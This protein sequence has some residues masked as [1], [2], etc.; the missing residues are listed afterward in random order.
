MLK[1]WNKNPDERDTFEALYN[2]FSNYFINIEP[3]Y[4][5]Y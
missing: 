1:C 5:Y 3:N 4:G 2:F